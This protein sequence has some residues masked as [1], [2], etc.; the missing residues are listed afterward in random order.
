MHRHLCCHLA[1][2]VQMSEMCQ[3]HL[4]LCLDKLSKGPWHDRAG[5]YVDA[6]VAII[7]HN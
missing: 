3:G 7:Y 6:H 2:A 4:D 5:Q 1:H